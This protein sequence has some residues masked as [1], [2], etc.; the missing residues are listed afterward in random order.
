MKELDITELAASREAASY[1]ENLTQNQI[2]RYASRF[3]VLG[4]ELRPLESVEDLSLVDG[5]GNP[6]GKVAPRWLCHLLMLRHRA[7]HVMITTDI[8]STKCAVLQ[9]RAAIK[10]EYPLHLDMSASGHVRADQ[11]ED[12]SVAAYREL[13]EEL[14]LSAYDLNYRLRLI[15][16]YPDTDVKPD[17]YLYNIE[18]RDLFIGHIEPHT[19]IDHLILDTREVAGTTLVPLESLNELLDGNVAIADA[20]RSSGPRYVDTL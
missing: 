18:Y 1:G 16:S 20:L 7:V 17:E 14:G 15:A 13:R 2:D 12:S 5:N 9:L 11:I 4:R 3:A 10:A 19:L 6:S 8:G